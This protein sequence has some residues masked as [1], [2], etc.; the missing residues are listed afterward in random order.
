MTL[1]V[2]NIQ[3]ERTSDERRLQKENFKFF[4]CS[5]DENQQVVLTDFFFPG[6]NTES[7]VFHFYMSKEKNCRMEHSVFIYDS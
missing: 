1:S 7:C 3:E 5:F 6:R 2:R 4:I